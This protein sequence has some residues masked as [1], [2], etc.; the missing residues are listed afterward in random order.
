MYVYSEVRLRNVVANQHQG[1]IQSAGGP[2]IPSPSHNFPYPEI[3]KLSR[4]IIFA[5]YMSLNVS[6]CHQNVWKFCPRLRQKQ[7]ER[8]INSKCSWGG[9]GGM[10]HTPR[11]PY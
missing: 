6:V 5:I 9:G 2:G 11:P 8:Y 7:S 1:F 4:V 10:G 3:L